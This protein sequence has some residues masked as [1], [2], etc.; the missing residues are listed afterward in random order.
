M[1][2]LAMAVFFV[3]VCFGVFVVVVVVV[4]V[5]FFLRPHLRAYGSS[6]A[7]GQN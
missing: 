2:A 6:Q 4:V 7:R 1:Y 5:W 3:C